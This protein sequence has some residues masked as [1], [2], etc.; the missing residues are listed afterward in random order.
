M[1]SGSTSLCSHIRTQWP[2]VRRLLA[3]IR[4]GDVTASLMLRKP[5]SYPR[6]NGLALPLHEL[7]YVERTLLILDS[8][9]DPAL[10]RWMTAILNEGE[11]RTDL[12][13]A[14]SPNRRGEIRDRTFE[15]QRHRASGLNFVTA[16]IILRN[17][18]VTSTARSTPC[19]SRGDCLKTPGSSRSRLSIGTTST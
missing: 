16:V 2:E 6:Q 1:C 9:Q 14:V 5:G 15:A 12:A 3:S 17:A 4:R 19:R 10:R 7:G 13:R 8:L 18:G 11:L